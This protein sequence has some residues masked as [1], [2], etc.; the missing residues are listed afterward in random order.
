[1]PITIDDIIA[2]RNAAVNILDQEI[3]DALAKQ[4]AAA[5]DAEANRFDAPIHQLMTQ[6]VAIFE[7]AAD[8]ALNS[9]EMLAAL[10]TL[11][12][13]TSDMNTIAARMGSVTGFFQ[14][15]ADIVDAASKVAG[16]GAKAPGA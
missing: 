4:N 14:N 2:A 13:L 7:Q 6:R 10:N 5:N 1:M 15:V 12:A 9:G 8:A 3:Q 16:V 11:R